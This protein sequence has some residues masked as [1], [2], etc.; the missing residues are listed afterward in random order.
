VVSNTNILRRTA[1]DSSLALILKLFAVP[2]GYITNLVIARL[3]GPEKMGIYYIALNLLVT[4]ATLCCLGLNTGLLRFV[5]GFKADG[6]LGQ[7]KAV[8]YPALA[9]VTILSGLAG[10]LLYTAGSWLK[11]RFHAPDLPAILNV[12]ALALPIMVITLLVMETVRA[13]GGV[14]RV[15]IQQHLLIPLSFLLFLTIFAYWRPILITKTGSM[16]LAF[17]LSA[18]LGLAFLIIWPGISFRFEESLAGWNPLKDLFIY[19]WP[20]FLSSILFLALN[21]LDSLILGLFTRPEEVAYYNIAMRTAPFVTFPLL[22]INAVVPPL[23]AQFHQ[24][25]DIR[26]LESLARSTARWMYFAALPL[27]II[28]VLLAP[29]LLGFFGPDFVKARFALSL[30]ALA[31]LLNVSVG[32]VGIILM[33]TDNQ[34]ALIMMQ[35]ITAVSV[36]PAM[37]LGAAFGGLNG[38]VVASSLGIVGTNVLMALAVWRRLKIKAFAQKVGPANFGGLFGVGLFYLTLPYVGPFGGAAF[39]FLGYL[40]LS[41][42]TIKEELMSLLQNP[43]TVELTS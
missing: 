43:G 33:M 20:I 36:V 9:I 34:W 41:G 25:G 39:F 26:G 4:V 38:M 14:R 40:A 27:A 42:K 19:S 6:K 16:G 8:F 18:L 2:L 10:L 30:L 5:A 32:S 35:T 21:G 15:V 31:Q 1:A 23:F 12:M 7:V 37:A 22:A 13:L 24:C 28:T 3:Y 11:I 17:F 29:V